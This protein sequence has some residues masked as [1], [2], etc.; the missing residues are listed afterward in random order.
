MEVR[1]ALYRG[2]GNFGNFMVRWWTRSPYSHCELVVDGYC[3]S[4][5]VMDKGVR[6]KKV[7]VGDD[8]INL[9]NGKWDLIDVPGIK[10]ADVLRY[11]EKTDHH[12][13][14]WPSLILSQLLN[15]N[16]TTNN[17]A[18]CSEWCAAAM[19]MPNPS[20]Y[21]PDTLGDLAIWLKQTYPQTIPLFN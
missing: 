6:A 3:Y 5:S 13:Y 19:G 16:V 18:F 7:G 8:E 2:P 15:S 9:N 21:N 14:G 1:L 17:K 11:F 10:A 20:V 4:A 12:T